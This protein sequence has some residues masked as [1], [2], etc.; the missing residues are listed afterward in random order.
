MYAGPL[1][2]MNI[3]FAHVIAVIHIGYFTVA[4]ARGIDRR[5]RSI[6]W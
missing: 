2:V 4:V 1:K 3:A 5:E 6:G